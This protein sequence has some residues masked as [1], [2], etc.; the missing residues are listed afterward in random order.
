MP[1]NGWNITVYKNEVEPFEVS[2]PRYYMN[3]VAKAL[4]SSIE[5]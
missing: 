4:P 5:T 3:I 2:T 1:E